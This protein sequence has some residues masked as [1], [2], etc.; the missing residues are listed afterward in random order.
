MEIVDEVRLIVEKVEGEN[1][2][3]SVVVQHLT[4]AMYLI[5]VDM[6]SQLM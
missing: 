1:E 4:D 3:H 6:T 2:R 5:E